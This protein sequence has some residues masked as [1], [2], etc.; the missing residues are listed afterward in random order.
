MIYNLG[1]LF[2]EYHIF[3]KK[4]DENIYQQKPQY[5]FNFLK[6]YINEFKMLFFIVGFS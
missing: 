5:R 2:V 6:K 4:I 1:V 3:I